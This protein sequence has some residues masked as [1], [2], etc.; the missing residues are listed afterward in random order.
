MIARIPG[1]PGG[2][3]RYEGPD[4]TFHYYFQIYRKY[5]LGKVKRS[6]F[7]FLLI[8]RLN[9]HRFILRLPYIA[10]NKWYHRLYNNYCLKKL[11]ANRDLFT[12]SKT[13]S[14]ERP[15]FVTGFFRSGTSLTTRL[16]N[17]LGMDLGP[18]DHLLLAKNERAVL[19]PEGFF[20]NYLFMETSLYAFS[21]LDSWGHIPPEPGKV[22]ELDFDEE[23]RKQFAEYTLCGVHDDRI[24]N[25]NKMDA[26]RNF[27]LL[28]LDSYLEKKFR[29]PYA[30]KNP[31]FA[32]LSPFLL[33]KWPQ[34]RF[35]VCFRLPADAIESAARITPMLDE[36]VYLRYYK[37]LIELPEEKIIFFSHSRLMEDPQHSLE[38]LCRSLDLHSSKI[39]QALKL[40]KPSLHRHK[41]AGEITNKAV[42]DIYE[43]MLSKA[44]NK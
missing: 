29:Y 39:P 13:I 37:E 42:K 26:L 41:T 14:E 2:I 15:L 25:R 6:S 3:F 28:S 22:E 27:D 7:Y 32:V 4:Q 40:I 36:N 43:L 34:A 12:D 18:E 23:D 8:F 1:L 44:I 21:K 11:G 9:N 35:L 38:T 31:H 5:P 24:S 20:E 16:L 10:P 30:I 33:K 19:N 17:A